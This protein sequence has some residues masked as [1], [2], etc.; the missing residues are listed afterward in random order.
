MRVM[1]EDVEFDVTPLD[2]DAPQADPDYG[3]LEF[4]LTVSLADPINN[5]VYTTTFPETA[6]IEIHLKVGDLEQFDNLAETLNTE[7]W[8]LN[9]SITGE[10]SVENDSASFYE[11]GIQFGSNA[12]ENILNYENFL[13]V[14]GMPTNEYVI[15]KI[16]PLAASFKKAT[17]E[18]DGELRFT[19]VSTYFNTTDEIIVVI[20]KP[21][22]VDPDPEP[23]PDDK[24]F[25]PYTFGLRTTLEL[26]KFDNEYMMRAIDFLVKE[27]IRRNTIPELRLDVGGKKDFASLELHGGVLNTLLLSD[28]AILTVVT[29]AGTIEFSTNALRSI[30]NEAVDEVLDEDDESSAENIIIPEGKSIEITIDTDSRL[31]DDQDETIDKF[32]YWSIVVAVDGT[33]LDEIEGVME[34]LLPYDME[35]DEPSD[36]YLYEVTDNGKYSE[37]GIQYDED[38]KT[39]KLDV[40][41]LGE[42]MVTEQNVRLNDLLLD[43][44][45]EIEKRENDAEDRA[46]DGF[47]QAYKPPTP[48][49]NPFVDIIPTYW[50]YDSILS[51]YAQ[52]LMSGATATL[53]KPNDPA[54]RATI[55]DILYKIDGSSSQYDSALFNLYTDVDSDDWFS[56]ASNWARNT[57][58][59]TGFNDRTFRPYQAVTREELAM[60]IYNYMRY[61]GIGYN[62]ATNL[63]VFRDGWHVS[64]DLT[65]PV[66]VVVY[67]RILVGSKEGDLRPLEIV[68]RVEL[69]AVIDRLLA[70]MNR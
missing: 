12:I 23:D 46:D 32:P 70:L 27:S 26:T 64:K 52:G 69:A 68:S 13:T 8:G 9:S 54:A 37:L 60:I 4:H 36:V 58:V 29:K 51:L 56:D 25:D 42:F 66:G 19:A 49:K 6:T 7:D 15:D 61:K 50:G 11:D 65:W 10:W 34:L 22:T 18:A 31:T 20:P 47:N 2:Y 16:Y 55:I 30:L 48:I 67:N 33:E 1:A 44:Q 45:R 24:G 63:N 5:T 17:T 57:Y 53:F 43:R 59:Y 39:I 35:G 40:K 38:D 21:D 41:A 62:M 3:F 28:R 14:N